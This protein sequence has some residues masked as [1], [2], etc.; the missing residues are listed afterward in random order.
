MN[1]NYPPPKHPR[2]WQRCLPM[3][4]AFVG[5]FSA[6]IAMIVCVAYFRDKSQRTSQPVVM[7][8]A[9]QFGEQLEVDKT[10]TVRALARGKD[11]IVR[12]ELWVDGQLIDTQ[13]SNIS[14]GVSSFPLLA[15]WQPPT[16]A[17]HTLT[18]RAFNT[19]GER[20]RTSVSVDAF[21][22]SD[23]DLD[24]VEDG[25]D[26][27]PDQLGSAF[28]RGCPDAEGD[29]IPD[30]EDACPMEYGLTLGDGCPLPSE[31][32][33]DGDGLLDETDACADD[34]GTPFAEGCPDADS[35][36][37][38]DSVD[39]C[40]TEA[41]WPHPD[42][43]PMPGDT[44][45]DSIPD[46][47]D[48]CADSWGL[49][50]Q[51]G[52]PDD[53]GDGIPDF[54]DADPHEPGPGSSSGAPDRDSDAVPDVEDLCPDAP[55]L[56]WNA[57]CPD[58][59]AGDRDNDGI[60]DDVDLAPDE[61]GLSEHG[62]VPPPGEGEDSNDDGIPDAEELQE[63]SFFGLLPFWL[64]D[65]FTPVEKA[66]NPIEIEVFELRVDHVYDVVECYAR[67]N[68]YDVELVTFRALGATRWDVQFTAEEN[69]RVFLLDDE[70]PIQI[71]MQ[72][73][74]Y[75]PMLAP[76]GNYNLGSF[77]SEHPQQ[78]W[79]GRMHFRH[80]LLHSGDTPG[81]GFEIHYRICEGSC[82][83][84]PLPAPVLTWHS[85]QSGSRIGY[86]MDWTWDGDERYLDGFLVFKICDNGLA[87]IDR[88]PRD[89]EHLYS[90][91][92]P[93][94]FRVPCD[95]RC[96]YFV[97]A[98]REVGA[99]NHWSAPSSAYQIEAD[100]CP[101]YVRVFF[102]TMPDF[103]IP[104]D[105]GRTNYVGPIYGD[106]WSESG[107]DLQVLFFNFSD[108]RIGHC[109]GLYFSHDNPEAHPGNLIWDDFFC[110]VRRW[111]AERAH[112]P[113]QLDL[114]IPY[115]NILM[116]GVTPGDDLT[117]GGRIMDYDSDDADDVLFEAQLTLS[118]GEI[119]DSE[120]KISDGSAEL[121]IRLSLDGPW[122]HHPRSCGD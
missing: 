4:I 56:P 7:I 38:G 43:C 27:C 17:P 97:R 47:D 92:V 115:T 10:A 64:S 102:E 57:G 48:A 50:E 49:P 71:Y 103:D 28:A 76:E 34:P 32:D 46:A 9:P 83:E 119:V 109:Q 88:Y 75:Q 37:V 16:S 6:V 104:L 68:D 13:I 101:T 66:V 41:G 120:Y 99:G 113:V 35:D 63:S 106:F 61:A 114:T 121:G 74:G 33:R 23:R 110:G 59:G 80:D 91:E 105:E 40:P 81:H 93:W 15:N 96:E 58:S 111:Q 107:G 8:R 72:C 36:G 60:S 51:E 65:I 18:V 69:S 90:S 5:V 44:D 77:T 112:C 31:G 55:G 94:F 53:D 22:L 118:P 3:L 82:E 24:G 2:F 78:D 54:V 70:Y 25:I 95:T 14:G 62:G 52:C 12:M 85:I 100:A 122:A 20:A 117:I 29:G 42:G 98:Y 30:A 84:S 87:E 67:V 73:Q 11:N 1:E 86:L 45:G 116:M 19:Q 39:A 21:D 26:A 108:C 89:R 79:N